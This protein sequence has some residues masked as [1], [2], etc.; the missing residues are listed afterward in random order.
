M[1]TNDLGASSGYCHTSNRQVC[2]HS[3]I[4]YFLCGGHTTTFHGY[5]QATG[6]NA[7][8]ALTRNSDLILRK[9]SNSFSEKAVFVLKQIELS[10]PPEKSFR[11]IIPHQR[12]GHSIMCINSMLFDCDFRVLNHLPPNVTHSNS[13][14]ES[15]ISSYCGEKQALFYVRNCNISTHFGDRKT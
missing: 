8:A 15:N 12:A 4:A 14:K 9:L 6:D 11:S 3:V 1:F 7:H 10:K 5:C 2:C 13:P